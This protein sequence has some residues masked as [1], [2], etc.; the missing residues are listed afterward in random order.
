MTEP[1]PA[2]ERRYVDLPEPGYGWTH[3]WPNA[4]EVAEHFD[5]AKWTLIGGLMVQAHAIAHRVTVT[6]PTADLDVLLHIEVE[7]HVA[8]EAHDR[9]TAMGYTLQEPLDRKGPHYRYMRGEGKLADK[10]DVMAAD[11]AAPRTLQELRG[12]EMFAVEGGTQALRR[13]MIYAMEV[14]EAAR[15]GEDGLREP[16]LIT[17]HR[18]SVPDELGALVLKGAAHMADR[19]DRDRHLFDAAALAAC[20]S[21]HAAEI[22]RMAGSDRKRIAHLAAELADPRHKA[23]LSLDPAHRIAGQDTL[24]ILSSEPRRGTVFIRR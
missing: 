3:P 23:W 6:R 16:V 7:P 9:L 14:P 11:H 8:S 19:R 18:I 13:T 1:H 15:P 12:R 21:D 22:E 5:T 17:V 20:I 24:R 2:G 10:I 4:F